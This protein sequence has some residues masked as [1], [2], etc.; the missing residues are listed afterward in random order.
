MPLTVNGIYFNLSNSVRKNKNVWLRKVDL[1]FYCLNCLKTW[2]VIHIIRIRWSSTR[3]SISINSKL[4]NKVAIN[5]KELNSSKWTRTRSSTYTIIIKLN[6]GWIKYYKS[7]FRKI[8]EVYQ[9]RNRISTIWDSW[10]I[11][12]C[13]NLI[14]TTIWIKSPSHCSDIWWSSIIIR[15]TNKSSRIAGIGTGIHNPSSKTTSSIQP[16]KISS[17]IVNRIRCSICCNNRLAKNNWKQF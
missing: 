5:R 16:I 14:S 2:S 8:F 15:I 7:R 11:S 13:I 10:K 12:L 4:K 6:Y 17:S 1:R 9:K 3:G